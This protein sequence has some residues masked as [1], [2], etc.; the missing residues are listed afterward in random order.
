M[1]QPD[2][3]ALEAWLL[4]ALGPVVGAA[5]LPTFRDRLKAMAEFALVAVLLR[6]WHDDE[7]G[8][9]SRVVQRLREVMP[10]GQ[11]DTFLKADPGLAP[12]CAWVVEALCGGGV[13]P[14]QVLVA[15]RERAI[16][17][18]SAIYPLA[19]MEALYLLHRLNR[20]LGVDAAPLPPVATL[21]F[22]WNLPTRLLSAD[23]IYELVHA[24]FFLTAFGS[25][26]WDVGLQ[27]LSNCRAGF[28]ASLD[29]AE[30][31]CLRTGNVDLIAELALARICLDGRADVTALLD[32]LAQAQRP[33]G[34]IA[35]RNCRG[36]AGDC[37]HPSLVALLAVA[38]A[39]RREA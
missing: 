27:V 29:Q 8:W 7:R 11:A 22:V 28:L 15:L 17:P 14:D 6:D 19:R 23:E 36:E 20:L 30:R 31:T 13:A 33:K 37:Y 2:R 9:S 10:R 39:G 25:R 35:P 1:V 4:G 18:P 12:G 21:C 34:A 3:E 24:I 32:E 5:S 16:N 26:H 38:R